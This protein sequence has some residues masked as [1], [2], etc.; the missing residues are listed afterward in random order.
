MNMISYND[1]RLNMSEYAR[2][3]MLGTS[4]IVVQ[5]SKP[6]FTIAP[7]KRK[8]RWRTVVDFTKIQPGG[9]PIEKA[10]KALHKLREQRG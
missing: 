6:L 8:E 9:V 2:R 3:V 7:V 10:M 5:K 4:F 1:L